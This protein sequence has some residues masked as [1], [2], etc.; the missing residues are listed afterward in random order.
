MVVALLAC[1]AGTVATGVIAYGER[2]RGPLAS[3]GATAPAG[4]YR[5]GSN[6]EDET[7][8]RT[9]EKESAVGELHATLAN[10]TLAL[11]VLHVLGVALA[12]LTHRENLPAAMITGKKRAED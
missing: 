6:V 7:I 11:V 5:R 10:I 8:G 3:L 12:S 1:L 4:A 9:E 2:G